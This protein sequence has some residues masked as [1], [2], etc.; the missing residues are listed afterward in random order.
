MVYASPN[1]KA[2]SLNLHRYIVELLVQHVALGYTG[3][4]LW[5]DCPS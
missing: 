1:Q 3:Y 5:W 4:A 2:V